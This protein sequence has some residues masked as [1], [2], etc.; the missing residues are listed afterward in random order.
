MDPFLLRQYCLIGSTL[1]TGAYYLLLSRERAAD[2]AA[3]SEEASRARSLQRALWGGGS[4][5]PRG[6]PT[7]TWCAKLALGGLALVG[8]A[9]W[10]AGGVAEVQRGNDTIAS[11]TQNLVTAAIRESHD[12][13]T[14]IRI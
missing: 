13:A 6:G 7:P 3:S 5:A 9:M 14:T 2:A 10:L 12:Q 4:L 1:T 8:W 11:V